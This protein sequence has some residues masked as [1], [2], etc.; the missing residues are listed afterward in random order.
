MRDVPTTFSPASLRTGAFCYSPWPGDRAFL[1]S[2]AVGA[3]LQQESPGSQHSAL[4]AGGTPQAA[5][6]HFLLQESLLWILSA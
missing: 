5:R 4:E 2:Q 1:G 3:A 6:P